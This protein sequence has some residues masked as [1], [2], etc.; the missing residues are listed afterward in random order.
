[1][2]RSWLLA[3]AAVLSL[4]ATPATAGAYRIVLA[5]PPS[6]KLLHGYGGIEAA[7]DRTNIALVRLISPGNDI[8]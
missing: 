4:A 5:S 1:M 7:D 3:A 8:H 6:G 2:N